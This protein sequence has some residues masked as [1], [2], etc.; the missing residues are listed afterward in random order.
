MSDITS[1]LSWDKT[2]FFSKLKLLRLKKEE[3]RKV[4]LAVVVPQERAAAY[5]GLSS[6]AYSIAGTA[7]AHLRHLFRF[8][9]LLLLPVTLP[10]YCMTWLPLGAYCAGNMRRWSDEVVRLIGYEGMSAAQCDIRQSIL[11]K[12]GARRDDALREE[13][14][15]CIAGALKKP[16]AIGHTRGLLLVGLAEV[17][18]PP[19]AAGR[20]IVD[21]AVSIARKV[22]ESEPRQAAR[23][24]RSCADMVDWIEGHGKLGASYEG[25]QYREEAKHLVGLAGAQDQVLKSQ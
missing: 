6:T 15:R 18:M 19:F 3:V 11:R 21:E 22:S 14:R 12:Q 9:K 20:P 23:I 10:L 5:S 13:A 17:S 24:L 4:R 25:R 2:D 16:D 8:P 1:R 7:A